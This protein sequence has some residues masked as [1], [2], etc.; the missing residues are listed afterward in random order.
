MVLRSV[1]DYWAMMDPRNPVFDMAQFDGNVFADLKK[2]HGYLT[3]PSL[4]MT[5]GVTLDMNITGL[6]EHKGIDPVDPDILVQF[7]VSA[8]SP[9]SP[10]EGGSPRWD[11]D[12]ELNALSN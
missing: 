9:M 11:W 7:P 1:V 6:G 4:D 5:G 8:I 3:P 12:S 2:D 10:E